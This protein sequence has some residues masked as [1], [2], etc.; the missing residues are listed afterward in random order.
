MRHIGEHRSVRS[1]SQRRLAWSTVFTDVSQMKTD[2]TPVQVL[3]PYSIRSIGDNLTLGALRKC[4]LPNAMSNPALDDIPAPRDHKSNPEAPAGGVGRRHKLAWR[5]SLNSVAKLQPLTPLELDPH[6]WLRWISG[7]I[8]TRLGYN[9][10]ERSGT[11]CRIRVLRW[12]PSSVAN[13]GKSERIARDKWC[14]SPITTYRVRS[15]RKRR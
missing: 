14:P 12:C 13:A 11:L 7:F 1:D 2:S 5:S 3:A 15:A 10:R 4:T 9:G 8:L 6:E